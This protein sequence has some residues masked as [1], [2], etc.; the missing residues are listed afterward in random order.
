M[1]RRAYRSWTGGRAVT[2]RRESVASR[3]ADGPLAVVA[4]GGHA[5]MQKGERG[6]IQEHERNADGVAAVLMA[7]VEREYRL[8]ITHGNGPQVGSLLTQQE[9]AGD[10]VQPMPLD[11]LVAMTEGSLGYI[12][13]QA[14][15]NRLRHHDPP[16]RVVATVTQVVVDP[17]DPAFDDPTKPIGPFLQRDAA[18]AKVRD[19]GWEIREERE[20]GWRR[21]VPSPLPLEILQHQM[22]ADAA[23]EGHIVIAGGGGGIPVMQEA[24]GRFVGVEGVVDKDLTAAVLASTVGASLLIIL[25]AVPNVYRNFGT[26]EEEPLRA[27][28]LEELERLADEDHF[29][30][31]SM[32]PKVEAVI[33]FLREGGARALV[34]DA[35]SLPDALEGRAGTHVVGRI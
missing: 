6:T 11:V 1:P 19:L 18:E 25:T 28:T 30:P 24:D 14:L 23:R 29:P 16:R 21:V 26:A 15:L 10:E 5:F 9:L 27:L 4:M 33:R 7:L 20:R 8:I 17:A 2:G 32:G 12:L 31:G 13:Q 22:I 35:R 3:R 34:T